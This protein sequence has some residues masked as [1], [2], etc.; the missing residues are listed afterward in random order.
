MLGMI[1]VSAEILNSES[2]RLMDQTGCYWYCAARFAHRA[3]E[4]LAED[5]RPRFKVDADYNVTSVF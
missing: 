3:I 2:G 1:A 4:L 5:I